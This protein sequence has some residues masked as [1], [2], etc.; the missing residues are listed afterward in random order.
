[1]SIYQTSTKRAVF[2]TALTIP[3][4]V[5]IAKVTSYSDYS[6]YTYYSDVKVQFVPSDCFREGLKNNK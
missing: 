6:H 1:M 4:F 3:C 5:S 2:S